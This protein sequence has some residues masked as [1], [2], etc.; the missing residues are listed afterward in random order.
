MEE[1]WEGAPGRSTVGRLGGGGSQGWAGGLYLTRT[2]GA[3]MPDPTDAAG[4]LQLSLPGDRP[5]PL[6]VQV[7]SAPLPAPPVK[8]S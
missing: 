3:V 4:R 8:S 1:G 2:V 7:P 5:R 6:P